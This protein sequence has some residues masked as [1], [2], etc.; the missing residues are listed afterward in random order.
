MRDQ[1][2]MDAFLAGLIARNKPH[3]V[4]PGA[5]NRSQLI[6]ASS[7]DNLILTG[8]SRCGKLKWL[9]AL[10]LFSRP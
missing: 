9:P 5:T 7:A 3:V 8:I 2:W 6:V 1:D 4:T 10:F